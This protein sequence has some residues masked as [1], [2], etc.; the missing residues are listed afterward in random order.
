MSTI[1]I[2]GPAEG[3]SLQKIISRIKHHI[4]NE[5]QEEKTPDPRKLFIE[6]PKFWLDTED[7][8]KLITDMDDPEFW[9]Q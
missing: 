7:M 4:E 2:G 5:K 3:K 1:G 9:L 8:R 6:M